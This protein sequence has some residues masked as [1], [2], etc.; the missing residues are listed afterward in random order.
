M[1]DITTSPKTN[2]GISRRILT[3]YPAYVF[4]VMF[5]INF[6]NYLDRNVLTGAANVVAKELGFGF[7]GIGYIAS[8]FLIVYTLGTVPLGIWA[9]RAKRRN[10]V[11]ICI[12]VWSV[13]TALTALATNF[14]TLFLS[15]MILG[16]GEAGYFPAGTALMSDYFRR[17][18]RSRVMSWWSVGQLVGILVGFVVG[19]EVAGLFIGSWRLAFIFTGIPGLILAFMAWKLREPRRNQ[20]D[21]EAVELD[22]HS[23]GNATEIEEPPHTLHISPNIFAQFRTLLTIKT[24]VVLIVMQI[25]AFFVLGVNVV[26]LPT[27]LQ[28]KDTFGLTSGQAGLFSGAVI[29][30][31]GMAGT[32]LGGYLA[33]ILNKRHQGAR[34]LVC[35]I[36]F[37]LSAPSFA[38]AVSV[39]DLRIFSIFFILTTLLILFYQGPS[40]AA[41]QDVVPS[42]LR[43]SAVAVSLL[44]AHLLGDAFAPSL[45]GTLATVF[46]PTHGQH[47]AHS[48]GGQDL[49]HALLITCTPALVIAGLVGIFGARWMKADVEAAEQADRAAKERG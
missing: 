18:T 14:I 19:G 30:F 5:S 48:V 40:T 4:W 31:A 6:L 2:A 8:A 10:V 21:E 7:D 28:Q 26:F 34:V 22:P 39:H 17:S 9:D 25:F 32:L 12:A 20:A 46:D 1:S 3:G 15:R 35:G 23:Y 49:S 29:V 37:L 38:L 27:Y 11:A 16:I 24:L 47:F 42:I 45:V 44:I 33:D 13:A 41:T 36:G 43:A